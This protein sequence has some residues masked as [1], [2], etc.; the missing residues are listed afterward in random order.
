MPETSTYPW[1]ASVFPFFFAGL[2]LFVVNGL[3]LMGGWRGLALAYRAIDPPRGESFSFCSAQLGTV[4]Y[5]GCLRFVVEPKGLFISVLFPFRPGH[6]PLCI[7]W[8]DVS[9]AAHR[10]WL[11][12]Y[13]D[14]SFAKQSSTRLRLHHGLAEKLFAAA[15]RSEHLP[16]AAE[17]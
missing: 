9:A 2:W 15:G 13:I 6:P 17:R 14:L 16:S 11:V 3:A 1:F 5:K 4:N 7:P 12:R 10:G 8:S